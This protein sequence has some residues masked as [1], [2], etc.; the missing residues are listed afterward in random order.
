MKRFSNSTKTV[1]P[2]NYVRKSL[3]FTLVCIALLNSACIIEKL[4]TCPDDCDEQSTRI[5]GSGNPVTEEI[6]VDYFHSVS[7]CTAGLVNVSQGAEQSVLVIVDDNILQY[8]TVEVINQELVIAVVSGVSLT[9]Y[10]LT[11]EVV[12]TDLKRLTTNSAGNIVGKTTFDADQVTLMANSAGNISL[13]LF[14]N[15]LHSIVNSAGNLVLS[16]EVNTHNAMLSSA[17]NLIAFDLYTDTSFI[18]INSAGN[19]QVRVSSLLDVT[20]NSAGSVYYKGNPT[21]IQRINS[22]GRVYS[23]D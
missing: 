10:D 16:G 14:A 11:V 21:V 7:M 2:H 13:N 15:Q 19:A 22:I 6:I 4:S 8:I 9:D 20:I 18:M 17:G 3:L 12:M 1:Y 5:K 23:V